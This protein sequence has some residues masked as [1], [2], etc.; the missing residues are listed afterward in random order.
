MLPKPAWDDEAAHTSRTGVSP[1]SGPAGQVGP[2]LPP[3]LDFGE[4]I[5][6][7]VGSR[8]MILS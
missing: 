3:Q 7:F 4:E 1:G 5:T 8:Q 2:A 6:H